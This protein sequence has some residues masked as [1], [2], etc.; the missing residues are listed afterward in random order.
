MIAEMLN[1]HLSQ[2]IEPSV[3]HNLFG[4]RLGRKGQETRERIL[5]ATLRLL[6]PSQA[7]PVT[8]TGV[9]REALVGMTN[10]YRYFPD[11]GDLILAALNRVM[12]SADAEYANRLRT[13]W[14]DDTLTECSLDFMKAHYSFWQRHARILHMRN[15]FA[16]ANDVRFVEYRNRTT[17]PLRDLLVLQ[18]EGRVDGPRNACVNLAT[19]LLIGFERV[20][21]VVTNTNFH[22][23]AKDY[24]DGDEN[25]YIDQ[26]IT[27]E[28]GLIEL[29]IR[30]QRDLARGMAKVPGSALVPGLRRTAKVSATT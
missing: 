7:T 14:P 25:A 2:S 20:A 1:K 23:T 8:L 29:A 18:M 3:S 15:S 30:Q 24:V 21:T 9:A 17:Y 16:D 19:V 27:A 6:E 5:T 12:D 22:T 13:H 10:L 26:L 11:I 4:Q 28:A